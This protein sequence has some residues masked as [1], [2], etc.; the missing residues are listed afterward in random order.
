[1]ISE[2]SELRDKKGEDLKGRLVALLLGIEYQI[3]ELKYCVGQMTEFVDLRKLLTDRLQRGFS[4]DSW[5]LRS[6]L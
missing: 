4:V 6:A 2:L 1:M 5:N 3:L